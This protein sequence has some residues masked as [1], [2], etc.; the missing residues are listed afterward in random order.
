MKFLPRNK[1]M[2]LREGKTAKTCN[3]QVKELY[4]NATPGRH[5]SQSIKHWNYVSQNNT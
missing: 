1:K 5:P 2:F 4:S 3:F